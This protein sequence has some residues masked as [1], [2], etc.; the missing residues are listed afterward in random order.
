[1]IETQTGQSMAISPRSIM[2][3][4]AQRFGMELKPFESTLKQTIMPVGITPSNEQIASFL[5]VAREYNLNPFTKE[6]YAFPTKSGGIQPIVSV[7][8]WLKIIN[9][10][11]DFDGMTISENFENGSIYSA[12]CVIYRK[13]RKHPTT[14][15]EYLSEC[16]R[17]TEQWKQKPIRMLR[18]KVAM[19]CARYAFGFAGIVDHDEAERLVDMGEAIVVPQPVVTARAKAKELSDA[20]A[21]EIPPESGEPTHDTQSADGG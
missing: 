12:T 15:T 7:D 2:G 4:M 11:P 1:M 6:I 13:D 20:L 19:Q 16:T 17:N 3:E 5:V 18:H 14:V 9:S 21:Q 8:G 10:H